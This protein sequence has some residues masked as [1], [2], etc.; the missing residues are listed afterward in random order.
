LSSPAWPDPDIYPPQ[1]EDDSY[2]IASGGQIRYFTSPTP[3][4]AN[5][6]GIGGLVQA[7]TY[8]LA[9][10]YYNGTQ[11]VVLN[12][13][14]PNATIRYTTNGDVPTASSG[15][16]VS[17]GTALTVSSTT[18]IRAVAY[19][20]GWLTSPIETRSYLFV[21]DI[22]DQNRP[23]GWPAGP[24]TAL[25]GPDRAQVLDYGMDNNVVTGNEAAVKASLTGIPTLS[26]VTDLDNLFDPTT[27]IYVNAYRRGVE[28]E[29]QASV[30][31]IDPSG[32][33][34]G[35]DIEAGIRIRGGYSRR[36]LNPKHAFRLFFKDDYESEL[37]YPL[38]GAEGD[39]RF[40]KV[41]LRTSSNFAWSWR[42]K[43]DA[44]FIDELWSRDT[45]GA[46]G[47]DYTRSRQYHLYING[48]YY[49]LY[50]TQE[51]IS[52]EF[53]ESYFGGDEDDYDVVKRNTPD[54]GGNTALTEATAGTID[55]WNSLFPLVSDLSVSNT[56]F[57][58]LAGEVDLINLADYYL[59]HFWTGDYDGSPS[60]YFNQWRVSNNW[61]AMRNNQRV[62]PAAKWK[63]FDHD[64][65]HSLCANDGPRQGKNVDNTPPWN[66]TMQ[67]QYM[68]PAM[69]H[70]ALVTHPAYRQIF[71]DRIQLHM[72]TPGGALTIPQAE[73]RLDA[74]GAEVSPAIEAESARWGDGGG[75]PAYGRSEWNNG[76]QRLRT[77]FTERLP[78]IESQLQADGLWPASNPPAISPAAGSVA[79]GTSVTISGGPGTLYF[80]TDGSDPRASDGSISPAAQTVAGPYNVTGDV[81]VR[82]RVR[83]GSQWSPIADASYVLSSPAGPV[84]LALNE[85]NAVSGGNFLG[86]GGSDA[87]LGRIA[88]NGGDWLELVVIE[89]GL[90]MRGW[91]V[92][93][94]DSSSGVLAENAS[95]TFTTDDL[96]DGVLA[97]TIITI[98]EDIADDVSYRPASGDWHFNLQANSANAG[99]YITAPSQSNFAINNNDTQIAIFDA[100]GT[101]VQ[102]RTGEGTVPG[103]SV[104]SSEVFKLEG[105][106]TTALSPDSALYA[107]GS[108]STWGL[109][110]AYSAGAETQDLS[111]LRIMFG[112]ANCDSRMSVIDALFIAQFSVGNRTPATCP[113]T[114]P[115]SQVNAAAA[116]VS[117]N[118]RVSV[119]DALFVAQCAVGLPNSFCPIDG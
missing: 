54:D 38:F 58:Q 30:E 48:L 9:H 22:I 112:D 1:S 72:L 17:P 56:E 42:H 75:D 107:D 119:Q 53:G 2:G 77:C 14:T 19:R 29:R 8:S 113:L 3:G 43:T 20:D 50:M 105:A 91:T 12:T 103:V 6:G 46:M 55:D 83:N 86:N 101:P 78:I 57:D 44:S 24:V 116:D 49:G 96:F 74:R 85:F 47:Q 76:V 110:N 87:T 27:G 70:E 65:E 41:D 108:S 92:Q 80:T 99:A 68:S 102:L 114:D 95:L 60:W 25:D 63:F 66:L 98:S 104:N 26:V 37:N 32:A 15:T 89:D 109:P 5:G 88:G 4:S 64:S 59:L 10:G 106:P 115:T 67:E 84:T 118:G 51:R 62:G 7:V 82:A 73:A 18:T 117:G 111:A 36:W 61:Y 28:W 13:P 16:A 45:Q 97:G 93:I 21:D 52:G 34:P 71:A 81:T 79:Y 23:S 39:D 31:L 94:W 90:D 11:T 33:E 35:F 69:L 40:E 100:A